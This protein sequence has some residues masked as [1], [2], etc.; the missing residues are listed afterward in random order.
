MRCHDRSFVKSGKKKNFKTKGKAVF[1][2]EESWCVFGPKTII[3]G[4]LFKF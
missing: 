4:P 1:N 2:Q 3:F